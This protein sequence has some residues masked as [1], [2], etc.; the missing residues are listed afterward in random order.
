MINFL[1]SLIFIAFLTINSSSAR[2]TKRSIQWN[3]NNWAMGCDFTGNDLS[4]AVV[5]G[6]D[7]NATCIQTPGCTHFT[8]TTW[9]TGTCWM[10]YG[11]ISTNNAIATSDQSMVCGV[12]DTGPTLSSVAGT[13]TRYWDCCKPSC[14]WPGKVSSRTTN[15]NSCSKDGY[16]VNSNLNVANGCSAGGSAYVCNNQQPWAINS[17]LAYGFAAANIPGL[18][19]QDWCCACYKLD[20]TSGTVQG[21]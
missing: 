17:Q 3:G 13:T 12:I 11:T 16:S 4:N 10:K 7:C 5:P 6:Q 14:A 1:L 15:V 18:S 21:Q 2:I 19:E 20:F 9:N 8:W